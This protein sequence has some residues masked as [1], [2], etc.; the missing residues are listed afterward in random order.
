MKWTSR[1]KRP[2]PMNFIIE[3]D[4]NVGFYL[5]VYDDATGK[6][7]HDYLQDTLEIAKEQA[8]EDFGVHLDSWKQVE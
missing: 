5:Y 4:K 1:I 2:K 7:T 6:N 3:H 8:F